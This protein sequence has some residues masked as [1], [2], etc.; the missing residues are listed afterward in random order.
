MPYESYAILAATMNFQARQLSR[1]WGLL[2]RWVLGPLWNRRNAAL[3]E[4]ALAQ[5]DLTPGLR[6]LEV[7]FGG[8]YLL[9]RI[10]Q[11]GADC[12][13]GVDH[14]PEMAQFCARR[15]ARRAGPPVNIVLASVEGLPF[16][17]MSFNRIVSVNSIF[18]WADAA[19]GIAE[20]SRVLA[21][22]G[23]MVLVFTHRDSLRKRSFVRQGVGLY[24]PDEIDAWLRAAGIRDVRV[25]QSNDRHRAFW[26][27]V[28]DQKAAF[29]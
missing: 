20:L 4:A 16:P 19:Q 8:G 5:L 25:E 28:G 2:G 6:V 7:G 27:M 23:R 11:A 15:F 14:S 12:L 1:P 3:N 29:S 21:P 24:R 9:D 18:Y 10:R 13:Y 22:G 26:V 17:R